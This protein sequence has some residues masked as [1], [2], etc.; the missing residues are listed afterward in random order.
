MQARTTRRML[1]LVVLSVGLAGANT[2]TVTNTNETGAGSLR[3]AITDANGNAGADTINFNI[4]GPGVQTIQPTSSLP[5]ITGAVTINGYSQPGSAPNTSAAGSNATLLI[6]LDGSNAG[7]NAFGLLVVTAGV[8]IRGLIIN[9][10]VRALPSNPYDGCGVLLGTGGSGSTVSGCFLGTNAAGDADLGNGGPGIFVDS[11]VSNCVIGG[12][13]P[14]DRNLISGN[15]V[16]GI[17]LAGGGGQQIRGNLLG[18]NAT[19]DAALANDSSGIHLTSAG[20]TI[21]GNV[22]SGNG[23]RGILVSGGS[24]TGNTVQ[25]N[26]IGVNA[27]ATGTLGNSQDG[28]RFESTPAASLGGTGAGEGNVIG[29]N[30]GDGV[31]LFSVAANSLI[32]GNYIGT[33]ATGT[34]N[35]GNTGAGV[36]LDTTTQAKVG[37]VGSGEANTIKF[38][39]GAGVTLSALTDFNQLRGNAINSN[40]GL[41]IDLG[42]NG[43]TLNGTEG[44]GANNSVRFPVLSSA[45][46][47][48]SSSSVV[49][50]VS[51]QSAYPV[52]VDLYNSPSADSTGYGEGQTYLDSVTVAS[53][54][55]FV[56]SG[57]PA[58]T[59]GTFLTATVTNSSGDTSEFGLAIVVQGAPA[60]LAFGT[61]PTDT[62]AGSTISSFTVEVQDSSGT[63]VTSDNATSV[64]IAFGNNPG[65]STLSGTVTRTAVNGICTFND[66]SLNQTGTGYTFGASAAG[67]TSAT[68]S[69]FDI[70]PGAVSAANSVA[71]VPNGTA[72]STT[73]ITIQGKDANGNNVTTGGATISIAISGANTATPSA[74]DNGDGTYT[75]TYPPT[76]TGNDFVAITLNGGTIS[77]SPYTSVVSAGAVSLSQSTA[78]VPAGTAGQVT[79]ITV[80]VRD[81]NGNVRTAGGDTVT[82]T[83]TGANS[84][85]PSVTDN[86]DGTYTATYT[87]TV[88]GTDSVAV[89]VGGSALTTSPYS[90]AVSPG[91]ASAA[92]ST[93]TVPNGTAGSATSLTVQA[94]D[95][96]GNN[97][98]SGG[99]TV[100]ISITGANSATPSVTDN[101]DGTYSASYTPTA[102]GNDS[103]AITL[104][105]S[106]ISGSPYSSTVSVGAASTSQSSASVP[107]GTAGQ[108]TTITVTVRDGNGNLR[109]SGGDTVAVT[110]SGANSATPAVTDNGDGTYTATYTPTASGTDSVAVTVGG[111]ALSASPYSSTV[112]AGAVSL[113]QSTA[114][115]PN[116]AVGA[117]TTLT[118]TVRDANGNQR[119]SGG[120]TVAITIT[121]ANT[122]TPAVTDNGNG[123]YTANYTPAATG[124]DSVAITVGGSALSASPYSSSVGA[125]ATSAAQTTATVPNGTAGQ[126]TTITILTRDAFGNA[127]TSG[128]D[129]VVVS[130]TG[131][132]TAAAGVVDN[133]TGTYTASYTPTAPGTDTVTITVNGSAISGSPYTS[134]VVIGP[135]DAA[136]SIATVPNGT[137][138]QLTTITVQARDAAGNSRGV[139]GDTVALTITGANPMSL[140]GTDNGDGTYTATYTPTTSGTDTIAITIG[141]ATISGSPYS[142]LVSPA[143]LDAANSTATVPN[144]T[145]GQ[146]TTILVQARDQYGNALSTGGGTVVVAITGTNPTT[147]TVT[148]LANGT[149]R[150]TYTPTVSGSDTV[151]IT[152]GG[153]T[154]A[155]SPFTSVVSPAALSPAN[156]TAVVPAN[157]PA[158]VPLTIVITARDALGNQLSTGGATVAVTITGTNPATPTVTDHGDGTYSATYTPANAGTDTVVIRINGN[159]ILGSPFTITVAVGAASPAHSTANVPNGT[160]GQATTITIQTRDVNGGT[161]TTGGLTVVVNVGGANTATP[162]VT[163]N[164]DGT[165]TATYTPTTAGPDT[166]AITMNGTTISGSPYISTVV[167]GPVDGTKSSAVVPDGLV[168]SATT[169][170]ITSRDAFGNPR[171]TGGASAFVQVTGANIVNPAV[172]DNGDGTYTASYTPAN[173]GVDTVVVRIS[174]ADVIGSPFTSQVIGDV[175]DPTQSTATVP[176]G[177]AGQVTNLT[178]Q[179]KDVNGVN[180]PVGG[181]TIAITVSG[182]NS[183]TPFATDP[184][185]GTYTANYTPLHTGTDLISITMNGV[186]LTGSPFS[187]TIVPGALNAPNSSLSAAGGIAGQ[188]VTIAIRTRD[189]YSNNLTAGGA[190]IVVGVSGDNTATPTVTDN[191]DGTYAASYT[192]LVKGTDTITATANGVAIGGS[193]LQLPIAI[194]PADPA[195]TTADVPNGQTGLVTSF[196]ITTRDTGNNPRVAGGDTVVVTVSGANTATPTVTDNHDGTYSGSYTP[197]TVGADSVAILING[198]AI[199]G[200]PYPSTVSEGPSKPSLCTAT[201]PGGVAGLPTPITVQARDGAGNL[202]TTGGDTLQ[203]TVSG[204]NTGTPTATDNGDGTYS[205]TYTPSVTGLDQLTIQLNGAGIAGS[206]YSSQV[207]PGALNPAHSTADVPAGV[208]GL[209]TTILIQARDLIGNPLDTGGA[210]VAVGVTGSNQATATVTDNG[211]GT[212]SAVYTPTVPGTDTIAITISN[213]AISGSPFSSA[214]SVG[215]TDPA[216]T[217]VAVP[218]GVTGLETTITITTRDALG[219]LRTTG[220]DVVTVE[221]TGTNPGTPVVTDNKNGTYTAVY[222]PSLPGTDSIAVTVNSTTVPGSP[223]T[224]TVTTGVTVPA[225]S[226]AVVPNGTAGAVTTIVVTAR[227][228]LGNPRPTGGDTVAI[229]VSGAN[230]ATPTVRDNRDGTYTATYTPLV[231]GEDDVAITIG[232]TAIGGSPYLSTVA[233]GAADAAHSTAN[234]PNGVAGEVTTITVTARDLNGNALAV[235][236]STVTVEI[237]G[238]NS[239]TP[240]VTDNGD[241]TYTATYT[242]TKT[243][244]DSVVIKLDGTALPDSPFTSTVA[245]GPV[246]LGET[247]GTV[248][249]GAAGVPTTITVV[250]YDSLGNQLTGGGLTIAVGI[251]GANDAT[252]FVT[253]LG[254][255][256]YTTT[257]TPTTPGDDA[258]A[259]TLAGDAIP[260]SPFTSTVVIGPTD[261]TTSTVDFP[262]GTAG[263]ATTLTITAKD[264]AG[265][266]RAVGGDTVQVT[267][268]GANNASPTV[269]D[270]GDGTYTAAYTPTKAGLDR[271]TVNLN[272]R[273]VT[274]SPFSSTVVASTLDLDVSQVT[275]DKSAAAADGVAVVTLTIK[276]LDEF[277]NPLAGI[278]P[279]GVVV[280]VSPTTG[281][282]I[283]TITKASGSDGRIL[284]KLTT[285]NVGEWTLGATI[286]GAAL[287]Q[288]ATVRFRPSVTASLTAGVHF[289]GFPI[290][291]D[292]ATPTAVLG[293]PSTWRMVRWNPAVNEFGLY[294]PAT[295]TGSFWNFAPGKGFWIRFGAD[296]TLQILGEPVTGNFTLALDNGWTNAANP[297]SGDLAWTPSAIQVQVDGVDKGTLDQ[298]ELWT[299]VSPYVWIYDPSINRHRLV[300]PG[301]GLDAVPRLN[302]MWVRTQV[303]G[304]RLVL[305]PPAAGRAAP[306]S[307][308]PR[309][310]HVELLATDGAAQG[311]VAVGVNARLTRALAIV[312]P[313]AGE[314]E[315]LPFCVVD[316]AGN[317]SAG[318]MQPAGSAEQAW[319]LAVTSVT[320]GEVTLSWPAL[321]RSLPRGVVAELTD[322][323]TGRTTLLNTRGSYR[324]TAGRAGAERRFRLVARQGR[325]ERSEISLMNVQPSRGGGTAVALTLSAPARVTL[326]VRGLSG[327]VVRQVSQDASEGTVTVSWD[328]LDSDGRRVPRGTYVLEAVATA[329]NGASSRATRTVSIN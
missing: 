284:V 315:S 272:A 160:A 114:N 180:R 215:T 125:G 110:I 56:A 190:N 264:P 97:L 192:P 208:A 221:V 220:G 248:P 181:D 12:A 15:G 120:D 91:A 205:A 278:G 117:A 150:A 197:S 35:L 153:T 288:T 52:T 245:A 219:N 310:W 46:T 286:N 328:G 326:T 304:V 70:T 42:N 262:D 258:V 318:E 287:T 253:D 25:G 6:E 93:A 196:Q 149:Y 268:T 255:G 179:A 270:N 172:T 135:T 3:Q 210:T 313:P 165:Y 102:T 214:V 207:V 223:F 216:Q 103:V 280:T 249:N 273:K 145:A 201:V 141:G 294:D 60:K 232:G 225:Q 78:S 314:T 111:S 194:G 64:T 107:N 297:F 136:H 99:A 311:T 308:T 159:A 238:A 312:E 62:Q 157:A 269:T 301:F 132:N 39:G 174:G 247:V 129:T 24:A 143:A 161:V 106:G 162:T 94:K 291:P 113:S 31:S 309:D 10:Y 202:R 48:A 38:N 276:L 257:Y 115:V 151:A 256:T 154:V 299:T 290:T 57:L 244:D 119:T 116:G 5:A 321:L 156:S 222:T 303:A 293:D 252:P 124:T 50:T 211:D 79:T 7:D 118:V 76:A 98:S 282:T 246:S 146:P 134:T 316:A 182:A 139:G 178:I 1:W 234:V 274:G 104:N 235:G 148:D 173:A 158:G 27:A 55:G 34:Q 184:G 63:V 329:A 229:A 14:A 277:G 185:N 170:E 186:A 33:D 66:L 100:V 327:R 20:N 54:G 271:A 11:G 163:D 260:N 8:T 45:T 16:H 30:G 200:S 67:L 164:A 126:V 289:V 105:G 138:G 189:D 109:A 96:Q 233:P 295:S 203:L 322:L 90:S 18:T 169:I 73:T 230:T 61:Q 212:Y 240:T 112:S 43:V 95:A 2:Y 261:P 82:I 84:A 137:A 323:E 237:T 193:P 21:V 37:G 77:G 206:P 51:N 92:Q 166:V 254:D 191:G 188:L 40:A 130:V 204:A 187:S 183:G 227:D 83:V 266:Q 177:I 281:L 85:T 265:N 251:T 123:T 108:V 218:D 226:D 147:P 22:I 217:N 168:A 28:I 53:A 263:L 72:G 59:P 267:I 285:P 81:A 175:G 199:S 32:F 101:G 198:T 68:S 317:R 195:N 171:Q 307:V 305:N 239:A 19:G 80:T 121:G 128:G 324:Y 133:G 250:T 306:A 236:G 131:A 13:T 176:N 44:S 209:P 65:G 241:G 275:V 302:G 140:P 319:D 292:E 144:G 41:G 325:L 155:G 49:G 47:D 58:V 259:I 23:D 36:S 243:G 122:A 9:R 87:P 69:A 86:G 300:M 242:P 231:A 167:A 4:P 17:Q 127:R 89:T 283:P 74:T 213:T 320:D 29:G 152:L 279:D 75:A 71:T 224:S 228:I 298:P 142:S 296:T 88:A 26:L